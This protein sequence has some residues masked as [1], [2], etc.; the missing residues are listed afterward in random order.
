MATE[1]DILAAAREFAA[2]T[3]ALS[4]AEKQ[5]RL[6]K[7]ASIAADAEVERLRL[8][9]RAAHDRL[10]A[11]SAGRPKNGREFI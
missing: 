2:A 11:V 8:V 7:E 9:A 1:A 6:A 3:L 4:N 5:W 10:L